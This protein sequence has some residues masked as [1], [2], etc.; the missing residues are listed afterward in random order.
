MNAEDVRAVM[1]KIVPL[2]VELAWTQVVEIAEIDPLRVKGQE[3]IG[4]RAD[5]ARKQQFLGAVRV[6]QHQVGARVHVRRMKHFGPS[7]IGF[8][9]ETRLLNVDD[10]VAD[11][12][13]G[14][15]YA[16]NNGKNCK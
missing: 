12:L 10:V 13:R 9:S 8:V 3:R 6:Q 2:S 15:G 7:R 16:A 4:H 14:G 11:R 1:R 5:P